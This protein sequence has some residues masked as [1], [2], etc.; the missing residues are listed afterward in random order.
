MYAIRK[1]KEAGYILRAEENK[2]IFED[3]T[4]CRY[5]FDLA[6]K[7][8]LSNV[9]MRSDEKFYNNLINQRKKELDWEEV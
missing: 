3:N 2:L 8:V 9:L 5:I 6:N 4:E 7:K 1:F